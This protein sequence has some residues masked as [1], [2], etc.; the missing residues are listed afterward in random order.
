MEKEWGQEKW[1]SIRELRCCIPLGFPGFKQL[2]VG[3][4]ASCYRSSEP[5]FYSPKRMHKYTI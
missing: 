1:K 5:A 2:K 3:E 4:V